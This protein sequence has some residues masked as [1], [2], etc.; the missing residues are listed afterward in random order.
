L[1]RKAVEACS[2]ELFFKGSVLI[3]QMRKKKRGRGSGK[4]GGFGYFELRGV[5]KPIKDKE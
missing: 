5:P 1:P 2:S 4:K 3:A